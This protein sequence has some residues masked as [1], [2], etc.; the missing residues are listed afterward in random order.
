VSKRQSNNPINIGIAMQPNRII[1]L[2]EAIKKTGLSR[3]TIYV[4]L[5]RGEFPKQIKLSPRA[6]GFLESEVNAWIDAKA[7]ARNGIGA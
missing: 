7:E 1:R 4:L 5:A 6:M 2:P 3:A